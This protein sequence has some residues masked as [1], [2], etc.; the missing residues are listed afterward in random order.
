MARFATY[1]TNLIYLRAIFLDVPCLS[2]AI[3]ELTLPANSLVAHALQMPKYS[4]Q[5]TGFVFH[6]TI[7]F[8]VPWLA[9]A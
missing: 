5:I 6:G 4:A 8:N 2:T 7:P 1:A 3:A 9:A